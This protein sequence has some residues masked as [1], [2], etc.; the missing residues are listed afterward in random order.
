MKTIG[1]REGSTRF[2]AW[3]GALVVL[4]AFAAFAW[5]IQ[6]TQGLGVT[7]LNNIVPWGLYVEF[8]GFLL[9]MGGG[10]L[11]VTAAMDIARVRSYDSISRIS[12]VLGAVVAAVDQSS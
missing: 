6:M 7:G 2:K 3:I 12:I 9:G 5:S 11:I 10:A 4:V 1:I 8:F